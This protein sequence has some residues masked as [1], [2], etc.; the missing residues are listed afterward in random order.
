MNSLIEKM[1]DINKGKKTKDEKTH[2]LLIL[3]DCCSDANLSKM[4]SFRKIFTRGR[5]I[6]ISIFVSA[7]YIFHVSPI[8]RSN[9]DYFIVGQLNNASIKKLMDEFLRGNITENQFKKLY[10]D[11]TKNF[12][13]LVINNQTTENNEI[14]NIYGK[15]K[16][17]I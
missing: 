17:I 1:T 4:P 12:S 16:A 8:I 9:A 15:I 10:N 3:D 13:F 14:D 2:I 5:H 6:G 7:Q 11:N